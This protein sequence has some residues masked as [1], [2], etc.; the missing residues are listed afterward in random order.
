MP[1]TASLHHRQE[2]LGCERATAYLQELTGDTTAQSRCLEC[3]L[4]KCLEDS[5]EEDD[6]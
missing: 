6:N 2:D 4:E 5:E 1:K 3:L